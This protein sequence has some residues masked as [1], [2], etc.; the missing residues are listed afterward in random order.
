LRGLSKVLSN[1]RES[2]Q[3]THGSNN[4]E[5]DF[6]KI[7]DQSDYTQ[8]DSTEHSTENGTRQEQENDV[9]DVFTQYPS[10][11]SNFNL[12][13]LQD[14]CDENLLSIIAANKYELIGRLLVVFPPEVLKEEDLNKFEFKHLQKMASGACVS[15]KG[16]KKD[17][18]RRLIKYGKKSPLEPPTPIQN[19]DTPR[20]N[21]RKRKLSDEEH[22]P[23]KKLKLRPPTFLDMAPEVPFMIEN[24]RYMAHPVIEDQNMGWKQTGKQVINVGGV[25][26]N[27]TWK[28]DIVV[29]KQ[30]TGDEPSEHVEEI[31]LLSETEFKQ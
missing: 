23:R 26:L 19:T 7:S 9:E 11:L 15:D 4:N 3:V 29:D 2:D 18:I 25:L 14:L 17:I 21:S 16:E 1:K 10:E 28:L 12:E 5:S 27:V 8:T 31:K 6:I 13:E 20:P 30:N 22:L 24:R